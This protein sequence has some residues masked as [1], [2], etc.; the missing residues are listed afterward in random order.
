MIV[1]QELNRGG[2]KGSHLRWCVPLTLIIGVRLHAKL[3]VPSLA[4]PGLLLVEQP[5]DA[6]VLHPRQMPGQP[7]NR[8]GVR[9]GLTM[10]VVE[11][12][13]GECPVQY[14]ANPVQGIEYYSL[15]FHGLSPLT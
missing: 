6:I 11:C 10:H 7:G 12:E 4:D 5:R 8:V 2:T 15:G 9:A 13:A 1:Q 3:G 14:T